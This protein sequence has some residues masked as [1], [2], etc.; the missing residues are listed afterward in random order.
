MAFLGMDY[1]AT[2]FNLPVGAKFDG[3]RGGCYGHNI[4]GL[5]RIIQ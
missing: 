5:A 1:G 3:G 2:K 4:G